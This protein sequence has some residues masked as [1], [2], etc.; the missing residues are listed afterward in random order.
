MKATTKQ[1]QFPS[2]IVE[3]PSH[4]LIIRLS[5]LGD[6]AMTI[7]VIQ[8]VQGTYPDLKITVLTKKQFK[9]IFSVM[10]TIQVKTIEVEKD[11]K[12]LLGL[13]TLA[14]ELLAL[15]VDRVADLHN[16]LRTKV[17]KQLFQL[18]GIRVKQIDKGRKEKKALTRSKNKNFIQLKSTHQR[19]ADVFK[20]LG[21]PIH[22]DDHKYPKKPSLPSEIHQVIQ[23]SSRKWIGIAPFAQYESKTYPLE[24]MIRVIEELNSYEKFD[25]FL[26]G[27]GKKEEDILNNIESKYKYATNIAGK[28]TLDQELKLI[29]NLDI[30]VSMDSGNAHLAAIYNLPVITLW[31][32]T[33]PYTGFMPFHQP[34]ENA[35]LSN[36]TKYPQIPTSVYG[37]KF[38]EGYENVMKSISPKTVIDKIYEILKAE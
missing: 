29:G 16:V 23:N 38:P 8:V 27:G 28:L 37:N 35:I 6:V 9:P 12:G 11:H 32:V 33:H 15:G 4:L 34:M 14:N 3:L 5:S 7:P 10:D 26:F 21:L 36:L 19:Y 20:E 30:M 18:R 31:G 13:Y 2:A 24:L 22:L 1:K 25:I 17:L